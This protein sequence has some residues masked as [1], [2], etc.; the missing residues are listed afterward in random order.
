V[1]RPGRSLVAVTLAFGA[2]VLLLQT[3]AGHAPGRAFASARDGDIYFPVVFGPA[4]PAGTYDCLEY[5]FGLIWT[6]EAVTLN[7]DGSSLYAYTYPY[8]AVVTGTWSYSRA[9]RQVNFTH[10]RWPS[11][12]FV[13][14]NRLWASRYLTEAGFDVALSC[15]KR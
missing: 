15:R 14:P 8:V 7:R 2:A 10:F 12:T 1:G 11:A 6:S 13:A 9:L 4:S 5:E 3:I